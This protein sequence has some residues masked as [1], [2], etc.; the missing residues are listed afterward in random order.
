MSQGL[1]TPVAL[2]LF[3]KMLETLSERPINRIVL[4]SW[5]RSDI[6]S[7][8]LSIMSLLLISS[9]VASYRYSPSYSWI[10]IAGDLLFVFLSSSLLF[11]TFITR[12]KRII[13]SCSKFKTFLR[14]FIAFFRNMNPNMLSYSPCLN[15]LSNEIVGLDTHLTIRDGKIVVLPAVLLVPGD[16]II[17]KPGQTIFAFCKQINENHIHFPGDVFVPHKLSCNPIPTSF[18][19]IEKSDESMVAVVIHSPLVSYLEIAFRS[20]VENSYTFQPL[21]YKVVDTAVWVSLIIKCS[22]TLIFLTSIFIGALPIG[23]LSHQFY[24]LLIWFAHTFGVVIA[25]SSFSLYF[26]WM[27]ATAVVTFHFQNVLSNAHV[28]FKLTDNHD[29]KSTHVFCQPNISNVSKSN[30]LTFHSFISNLRSFGFMTDVDLENIVLT[31]GTLSS[32]CCVNQ[33]GVIS[34]SLPTPEKMFFFHRR[35][36]N[37]HHQESFGT[38]KSQSVVYKS[39]LKAEE[40]SDHQ[41]SKA[42]QLNTSAFIRTEKQCAEINQGELY[43]TQSSIQNQLPTNCDPNETL[44]FQRSAVFSLGSCVAPVVLDLRT[45]FYRPFLP[46]FEKPR[47][48]RFLS[49]LKPIGLSILLNNCHSAIAKQRIGFFEKVNATQ[50]YFDSSSCTTALPLTFCLC[51]L[52][53]QIG[54]RDG[55]VSGFGTHGCLGAYSIC[56]AAYASNS[57]ATDVKSKLSSEEILPTKDNTNNDR[58]HLAYCFSSVFSDPNIQ[59]GYQLLSQGTGDIL[60]SLCSDIW[61][62]RD[63][64][65]LS[66]R[67]RELI[68]GFHNRHLSSAYCIGFAYSPLVDKIEESY[69]LLLG[70][71]SSPSDI[72]MLRLPGSDDVSP[73]IRRK[74]LEHLVCSR[75]YSNRS[76]LSRGADNINS[77]SSI[78]NRIVHDSDISRSQAISKPNRPHDYQLKFIK[79]M[80]NFSFN[81]FSKYWQHRD[82]KKEGCD[83]KEETYSNDKLLKHS[84]SK[85]SDRFSKKHRIDHNRISSNFGEYASNCLMLNEFPNANFVSETDDHCKSN[86]DSLDHDEKSNVRINQKEVDNILNNQIFLGLISMQYQANPQVVKSIKQLHQACIRFV[87][88]SRENELRSR[89]FAE[90][91]GLECGWNCHI[92][93]KAPNS[94]SN[95][96]SVDLPKEFHKSNKFSFGT[97]VF[98]TERKHFGSHQTKRSSSSPALRTSYPS[99]FGSTSDPQFFQST[100]FP[101]YYEANYSKSILPCLNFRQIDSNFQSS[102]SHDHIN[103]NFTHA[104]STSYL[105]QIRSNEIGPKESFGS[106]HLSSSSNSTSSV[107]PSV[108]GQSDNSEELKLS[109]LLVRNKSRLPCGIDSIRPHLENVDNVPLQVSLFTDCTPKAVSEMIQIMKEYGDTVC[110]IGSCYSLINYVLFQQSDIAIAVKPILPYSTCQFANTKLIVSNQSVDLLTSDLQSERFS[111]S[112]KNLTSMHQESNTTNFNTFDIAAHLIHLVTPCLLD[113]EKTGF[114]VYDL[115]VEAHASVNNLYH[116]LVFSSTTPLAVGLLQLL[117][118][119]IGLPTRPV[120]LIDGLSNVQQGELIWLPVEPFRSVIFGSSE[121]FSNLSK[122]DKHTIINLLQYSSDWNLEPSFSI[123]Q[124]FWLLFIVIP[125]LTLS[126]ID[127]QVERNQP[128]REPPIKRNKL[129]TKK[130]CLRFTL[131]TCSRFIPSLL[132]CLFCEMGHFLWAQQLEDCHQSFYN[133]YTNKFNEANP[134]IND[135][136][137]YTK[138]LSSSYARQESCLSKLSILIYS[139]KDLIFYQLIMYLIIISFSY[140]NYGQRV[141]KFRYSTNPSWCIVSSLIFILHSVYMIIRLCIVDSSLRLT[142]WHILSP[143]IS[144]F[145]FIWCILL[146]F[147][148]DLIS[149]R[150]KRA[151]LTEHRLSRL[152]FNTKLGMYSPV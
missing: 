142:S 140:A 129:F 89:V 55:A 49:S 143:I 98:V 5:S 11:L 102:C 95:R 60:A 121:I 50:K 79:N 97:D 32:V 41:N 149:W 74:V 113:I 63:I 71:F 116:C 67:E 82:R 110:L 38:N 61:D 133:I 58:I 10:S 28:H 151:I 124:L 108:D 152:Y 136:E 43:K 9:S 138:T 128:L 111:C 69:R 146:L 39:N 45:D 21:A 122:T 139:L 12:Y 92:S 91:L 68:L 51:G 26:I 53:S 36:H 40:H 88:F 46:H 64:V 100:P 62:G 131:V 137:A 1:G 144:A 59:G 17:I 147:I 65:P 86:A 44:G 96:K 123:G 6:L 31:L 52:A 24:R 15:G 8:M 34:Q 18:T 35:H 57:N 118:L 66:D 27:V 20:R 145:G 54:F 148:N 3:C 107:S 90:R 19:T 101:E 132:I 126:L 84:P 29:F 23:N 141:W 94:V 7:L 73:V 78:Y 37:H 106:Y 103:N 4:L 14:S 85:K 56:S 120:F 114:H 22:I 93:L 112:E 30:T 99:K 119:I 72:F 13:S 25:S 81:S 150:E 76:P 125:S 134:L 105:Q 115:I 33:E 80:K 70:N 75:S 2:E 135:S 109:E 117:L 42:G 104:V 87:H 48:D 83:K 77:T 16:V 130:R 47:W 127:R